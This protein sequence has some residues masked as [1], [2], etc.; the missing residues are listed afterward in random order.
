MLALTSVDCGRAVT[1]SISDAQSWLSV[2][3]IGIEIE[4][5]TWNKTVVSKVLIGSLGNGLIPWTRFGSTV[6]FSCK[7]GACG[8]RSCSF[9]IF[10]RFASIA[11]VFNGSENFGIGPGVVR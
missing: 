8:C 11:V 1:L 2:I 10:Q 7:V 9:E 5:D 6:V 3:C 4:Q